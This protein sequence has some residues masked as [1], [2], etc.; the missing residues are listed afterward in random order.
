MAVGL[1]EFIGLVCAVDVN[2]TPTSIDDLAVRRDP[3]VA[4]GFQSIQPEDARGDEIILRGTPFGGEFTRRL[5]GLKDHAGDGTCPDLLADLV[6]SVRGL[7]RIFDATKASPGG[8]NDVGFAFQTTDMP[9]FLLVN[10]HN[11]AIFR[12]RQTQPFQAF[13][14]L[15]L[16][17]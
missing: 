10:R 6:E 2:E 12:R 16:Q 17:T 1:T 9:E 15:L 13:G 5:T 4:T 11:D 3:L 8:T 14:H 7:L